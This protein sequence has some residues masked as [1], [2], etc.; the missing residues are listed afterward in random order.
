ELCRKLRNAPATAALPILIL[1]A[2]GEEVDRVLGLEMGADD[3]VVK[4]F[5]PRELLARIKGLLRRARA[6]TEPQAEGIYER[7]RVRIDFGSYQ[8]MVDGRVCDLSVREFE[9]L[10][11]FVQHPGRVYRREQ[12]LDIVWGHDVHVEPRTVDVLIRRLRRQV[13]RDDNDPE[14]ILTVRG[15]G[16]R[17]NPDPLG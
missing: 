15:V 13:E 16:Y 9:L 14:L 1:T 11:F 10:K 5:S 4:P 2:R 3:Y 12:L 6:S 17:F 7:G 8:V